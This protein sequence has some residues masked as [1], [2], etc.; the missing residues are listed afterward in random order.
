M[1]I[2]A[3][4]APWV[5]R[6]AASWGRRPLLLA[7]LAALP[8]RSALFALCANPAPL[9]LVQALDGITGATLGVLTALVIAD[10]TK[11]TGRFN[12]AQGFVGTCSGIGA[13]LSTFVSGLVV[14]SYGQAA[15]FLSATAVGLLALAICWLF[16]PETKLATPPASAVRG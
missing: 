3:I 13:A 1:M 6:K 7:G 11:G 4:L 12:L 15:G 8:I 9:L 14:A 2:V 5:G 10:V 16:M